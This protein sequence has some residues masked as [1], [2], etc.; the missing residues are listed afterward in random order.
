M[1]IFID[2]CQE[3]W[4]EWLETVEFTYNNKVHTGTKVLPFQANSGQ[5]SRM[6]FELRKKG[7]YERVEQFVKK[8][9]KVEGEAKTALA[10]T[11]EDMRQYADRHIVE[12]VG[13]KVRD[14]VLL[15]TK[16]L[17]WQ[18][19]GK[20]SEKL[21]EQFIGPYKIKSIILAN[22]VELELP[23]TIRISPVVNVSRIK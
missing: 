2:Y 7:K 8:M 9:E 3:Q 14:L 23:S 19:V 11:P 5:N 22:V 18:M 13:Y 6:G 17:K 15:S 10:K 16:D 4:P 1:Y 12:A 21:M 20:K